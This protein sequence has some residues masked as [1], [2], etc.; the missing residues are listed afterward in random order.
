MA[1]EG[2]D[3]VAVTT[4]LR[5]QVTLEGPLEFE[6]ITGGHSNLTF[7]VSDQRGRRWVL[8]RPPLSSVLATAHD[9]SREHRIISALTG[10]GVPV[11][12]VVALCTDETVN[13][14]SFYVM[15]FV[16]GTV[17]RN[18]T[19][20]ETVPGPVRRA[21]SASLVRVL[22]RLHALDPST[23][24]LGDL[25]KTEDY[26]GR[27]LR[28]WARQVES[29]SQRD[30]TQLRSVHGELVA[31]KPDQPSAGIVHGDYKLENCIIDA[32]GQ[33][34]AV[35]DWELCTLGDVR[36]DLGMLLVYWAE[37][38][39]DLYPLFSPP[40]AIGGFASRSEL[41]DAY[42]S[43]TGRP[44]EQ[45]DYF[46]AFAYWRLACILEGVYARYLAGGMGSTVPDDLDRYA[47]S[48]DR[49]VARAGDILGGRPALS[50]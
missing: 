10:S 24:G 9:M 39:D 5:D 38:D 17:V 27:Q 40:T 47:D 42:A 7:L 35:L 2:I 6:L 29:Q 22:A 12:P 50:R 32:D 49:L 3:E 14:A 43:E 44:I 26:V 4:W 46:V 28:R 37:P 13:G 23:V 15:G 48:I 31:R 11:P 45:V 1:T 34:A 41:V 30:L 16:D 33:V 8:R 18:G 20:A 19:V 25:G 36:A 21:A